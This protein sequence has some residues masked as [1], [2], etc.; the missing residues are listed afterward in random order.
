MCYC[1]KIISLILLIYQSVSSQ[2]NIR[3]EHF[4]TEDGLS[5]LTVLTIMQG[6]RGFLWIGTYDGLDRYDGYS[7]KNFRNIEGD[8]TS[9]SDNSIRTIAEDENGDLWIGTWTGGVNKFDRETET[10]KRYYNIPGDSNSLISN[11]ILS[12][13]IDTAGIVWIGTSG[14]LSKFDKQNEIFTNYVHDPQDS[15]SLSFNSIF[16]VLVSKTGMIWLSTTPGGLNLLDPRT[17]IFK[18][19]HHDPNNS[20]SISEEYITAL[21]ED[22]EGH[23]WIGTNHEGLD[24]FNPETN[25]F[26]NYKNVDGDKNSLSDNGIFSI[27]EDNA[28]DLWIGTYDGGLNRLNIAEQSFIVYNHDPSDEN[29]L[30]DAGVFSVFIDNSGVIWAG[31]WSGGLNKYLPDREKI[32]SIRNDSNDPNSLSSN[33]VFAIYEDTSD[34]LWIGTDTGGLSALDKKTGKFK[35]YEQGI[36][37][38]DIDGRSVYAI[39]EDSFGNLWVGTD[40]GGVN[41][42][43]KQTGIITHYTNDPANENSLSYDQVSVIYEDKQKN[44]WIGTAGY[45]LNMLGTKSETFVRYKHD[46]SDSNSISGDVIYSIYEDSFG[47]LWIGTFGAGL[48]RFNKTNQSFE[49][50]AYNPDDTSSLSNNIVSIIFEDK[51]KTL[52]IGTS[53]GLNYFNR[54][55]SSF[56][57]FK[58][59]EGLHNEVINGILEDDHDNLW[60]STING[61]IVFNKKTESFRTYD[62]RDGLSQNEFNQRAYHKGKNGEM[63][64]GGNNGINIFHPDSLKDNPH[65]PS[66]IITD[67]QLLHNPVSVGYNNSINRSI[68]KKSITETEEIELLHDDNVISFEFTALDFHIPEKNKYAYFMEGFDKDWTFTDANR[69]FVTYTNLDPGEYIFR[70]KGSNNDGVWNEEG[71]AVKIIIPPPFW[72]TWWAYSVY[73]MFALGLLYSIRRYELNRTLLKSQHKLDEVKLQEREETDRLKSRFFANISHE[74]RTPLTLILGPAEKIISKFQDEE[75]QKQTGLIKRN[76]NRLL[77]LINQLLDLSKLEAG[78]LRLETSLSNIVP[79]VKGITMSFELVAERKDISLRV[80]SSND[81]IEL[82]FDREKMTKIL[83][84]L[85]SNAFKFTPEGGTVIVSI[86]FP[87]P[88]SPPRRGIKGVGHNGVHSSFV[89]ITISDSG[90]GIAEEEIPK[91]FDRFYQVDSSQTREHEGTGIGLALTKE[92]V[93]LHIGS[94]GVT[95]KK[96]EGTEFTIELPVGRGH[97]KDEEIVDHLDAEQTKDVILSFAESE[98]KNLFVEEQIITDK[99]DSS[100]PFEDAIAGQARLRMTEND[101]EIGEEKTIILVVEDNADV[102]EFIKDSLGD[103]FKIEEASN[104]EQGVRKAEKIIPDLIISD[105]MMPKMD[106]NE[107]TRILKNDEKTSHIP[108]ILLT[109]KSEQE[110]KLEGLKTGADAYLTKPFD[111]E[112]LQIRINNLINIR[113]KLQEVYSKGKYLQRPTVNKLS[114]LDKRF[115]IK[116]MKIIEQHISEEEFSIE[117]FVKELDIGNMQMHRK[118]KALTG[119]SASRYIRSVRLAR[120]KTMIEEKMG[121]I[122]EIAYSVGFG[123]PAYFTRCFREEYGHPPSDLVN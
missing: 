123:S 109:A 12:I 111:T 42:I 91:L 53:G 79:F 81:E 67:F 101:S 14:G 64:F 84:N 7:F 104:G 71:A 28:G 17:G 46:K 49:R 39:C 38:F 102:R 95:S 41:K 75:I 3:F 107:L 77:G 88:K 16:V 76:A 29:S 1:I 117:E 63:L 99:K 25:Q 56:S 115:M 44:I 60:L 54:S 110:S 4:G 94:I 31:T 37:K 87:T 50:F 92:L 8:T 55:S 113:R 61:I 32:K 119:K 118:L 62:T 11:D 59:D 22:S 58:K 5:A 116:V 19:F 68:L 83:T 93:E 65:I 121:N 69:R 43:N 70:V 30:S 9:L 89:E 24:Y 57:Y 108:I 48:N 13:D 2:S 98:A 21:Y 105:I 6:S 85:L 122:S 20:N 106:G 34:V 90:A 66:V 103:E 80:K 40:G 36:G 120:A 52:W 96:G 74:F 72:A 10:F 26:I 97:L 78:K 100:S 73:V 51:D 33:G 86:N 82:Y 35:H 18:H 114:S 27:T 47:D 23:L 112:E 15:T 45:G